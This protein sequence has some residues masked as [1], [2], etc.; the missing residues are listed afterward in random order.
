MDAAAD[1]TAEIVSPAAST[2]LDNSGARSEPPAGNDLAKIISK[3]A[4]PNGVRTAVKNTTP[5]VILVNT[6]RLMIV[7]EPA[8]PVI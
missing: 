6:T 8:G 7:S 2:I 1:A 3:P 5:A 4:P